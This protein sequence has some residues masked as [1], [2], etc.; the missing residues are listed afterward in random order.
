M[1]REPRELVLISAGIQKSP[2]SL[3]EPAILTIRLTN[4]TNNP[5]PVGAEGIVKTTLAM[6][7]AFLT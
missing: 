3:G 1:H 6:A 5:L 2:V 7:G 4:T